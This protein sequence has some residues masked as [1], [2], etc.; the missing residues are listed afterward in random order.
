MFNSFCKKATN[1]ALLVSVTAM[2]APITVDLILDKELIQNNDLVRHFPSHFTEGRLR[3]YLEDLPRYRSSDEEEDY[4]SSTNSSDEEE[5]EEDDNNNK[6]HPNDSA[7][8]KQSSYRRDKDD[9]DD[10]PPPYRRR[11]T[12]AEKKSSVRPTFDIK[13]STNKRS[14]EN[15]PKSNK[16]TSSSKEEVLQYNQHF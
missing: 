14:R 7:E 4:D 10:L 8:P 1:Q 3:R 16:D 15:S 2:V 12:F 6:D 13:P 9:D 5:E 11:C